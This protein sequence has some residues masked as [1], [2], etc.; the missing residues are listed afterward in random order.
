YAESSMGPDN[1]T[2]KGHQDKIKSKSSITLNGRHC[3][4]LRNA[5]RIFS[6]SVTMWSS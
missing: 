5:I 2:T 1:L 4:S 6:S 3:S